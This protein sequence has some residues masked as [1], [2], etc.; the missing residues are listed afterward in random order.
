MLYHRG[1]EGAARLGPEGGR[2]SERRG[3]RAA[4]AAAPA[5]RR[6]RDDPPAPR[7]RGRA[8]A[9]HAVAPAV[10]QRVWRRASP[11]SLPGHS[12]IAGRAARRRWRSPWSCWWE[13]ASTR[14]AAS[15]WRRR[16]AAP[17]PARHRTTTPAARLKAAPSAACPGRRSISRRRRQPVT[18]ASSSYAGAATLVWA[19]NL[20]GQ[21]H[22]AAGL[23]VCRADASRGRRSSPPRS[24]RLP[25][26]D[27]AQGGIGV[28]AGRDFTLVVLSSVAQPPR[29]PYRQ[30]ERPEDRLSRPPATASRSRRPTWPQHH[31][32]PTWPYQT[33]VQT[34]GRH[35][36]RVDFLRAFDV[37]GL[38]QR[39][40][41]RQRRAIGTGPRWIWRRARPA[42]LK[43]RRCR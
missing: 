1:A 34:H 17:L 26:A 41:G 11:A 9:A 31:L 37:P 43:G 39:E 33:D 7:L 12:R 13:P 3:P 40:P 8:V 22:G 21:R 25:S 5:R 35:T 4:G 38:G 24:A 29:E 2:V 6:L 16:R 10:W 28:Y 14:W 15:T 19:G 18:G 27:V 42:T 23:Q 32:L 20:P 30:R 36:V